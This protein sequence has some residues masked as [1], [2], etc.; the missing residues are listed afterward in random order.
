LYCFIYLIGVLI[1]LLYSNQV[2]KNEL[3]QTRKIATEA[4]IEASE[5]Q[6]ENEDIKSELDD[7]NDIIEELEFEESY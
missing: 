5:V 7:V 4:S 6:E 2:L 1:Y 3:I